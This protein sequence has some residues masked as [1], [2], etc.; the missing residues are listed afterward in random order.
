MNMI[1]IEPGDVNMLGKHKRTISRGFWIAQTEVTQGQWEKVMDSNPSRFK[2]SSNH[3]VEKISYLDA[4]AFCR[5]LSS[6]EFAAGRLPS[7]FDYWLP[8]EAQWEYACR[9]N[10]TGDLNIDG[11]SLDALGWY[12]GN[13]GSSTHPVAEKLP[14]YFKLY[15][16]HGNVYEWTLDTDTTHDKSAYDLIDNYF[17]Q[18][19]ANG[20]SHN[21]KRGLGF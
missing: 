18:R 17:E 12:G 20:A 15:D 4:L 14:N 21:S 1:W 8:S 13:S 2:I 16:M 6:S 9:G 19:E 7:G 11:L 3:P 10:T 5:S